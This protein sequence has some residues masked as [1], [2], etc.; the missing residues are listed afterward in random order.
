MVVMLNAIFNNILAILW[1]SILVMEKTGVY[2]ENHRP[3]A[4]HL[5][6][7]SYNDVLS[8]PIQTLNFSGDRHILHR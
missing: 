3:A 8:R 7:L 1:R 6:T 2:G 4:S 5:Q